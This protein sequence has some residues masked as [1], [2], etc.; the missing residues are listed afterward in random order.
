MPKYQIKQIDTV[1]RVFNCEAENEEEARQKWFNCELE[2]VDDEVT[3]RQIEIEE[4]GNA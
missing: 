4:I 1:V 2:S 3:D